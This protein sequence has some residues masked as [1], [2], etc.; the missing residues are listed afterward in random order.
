MNYSAATCWL[1]IGCVLGVSFISTPAKFLAPD[2]DLA[3]ALAV[4]RA[5][6][7]VMQWVELALLGLLVGSFL[8]ESRANLATHF[9]LFT[10]TLLLSINCF[11]VRP[12]LDV[13]V[14][15]II[16]G[17]HL[18]PSLLHNVYIGIEVLKIFVLGV[19]GRALY[20]QEAQH[21]VTFT[22]E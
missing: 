8:L 6:F 5:T 17:Q 10:T 21:D 15:S 22:D 7:W 14:E 12:M 4:G 9:M 18:P 3:D 20:L 13:R 11:M 19:F 2:L 16:Q 1:W